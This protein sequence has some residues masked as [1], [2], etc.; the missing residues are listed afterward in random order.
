MNVKF[1]R[2]RPEQ[3]LGDPE[4]KVSD[5]LEFRHYEGGKVVTFTHRPSSPPGVFLVL[6]FRGWVDPRA[7]GSIGSFGKNLPATPLGIDPEN[8]R[9]VAQCLNHYATP[10]PTKWMLFRKKKYQKWLFAVRMEE[11]G[12]LPRRHVASFYKTTRRHVPET[13]HCHRHEKL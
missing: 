2:C 13:L 8:L 6:I 5:F 9:L 10:G 11:V 4:V 3:A 7:H 12:P 1:S